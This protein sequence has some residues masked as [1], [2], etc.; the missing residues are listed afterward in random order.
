MAANR[1]QFIKAMYGIE[2]LIVQPEM[3]KPL[4]YSAIT[5]T[6]GDNYMNNY[7]TDNG[8]IA[9]WLYKKTNDWISQPK[10]DDL[11]FSIKDKGWFSHWAKWV[12][13]WIMHPF[14][15][16]AYKKYDKINTFNVF[17][18]PNKHKIKI[19]IIGDWGTG[20]YRAK[21]VLKKLLN[22]NVDFIIHLGDLYYSGTD[23][24]F[25]ENMIQP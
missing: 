18:M 19:G 13:W 10:N 9:N 2:R 20:E 12:E 5:S 25:T 6:Y 16:V 17:E 8:I 15:S 23:N 11:R 21:D 22:H 3:E 24:E 4:Y 14:V 7:M 1:F